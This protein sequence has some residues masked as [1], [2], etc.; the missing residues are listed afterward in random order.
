M[1]PKN[2]YTKG[3]YSVRTGKT[4]DDFCCLPSAPLSDD[5]SKTRRKKFESQRR[6]YGFD[7]R[8][9]WNLNYTSYVW[10]YS[11]LKALIEIDM[12]DWEWK[13]D[14]LDSDG[15][16]TEFGK[17]LVEVGVPN[18][19]STK[20]VIDYMIQRIEEADRLIN[21]YDK[22][23]ESLENEE[24]GYEILSEVFRIYGVLLPELWW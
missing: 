16:Y 3:L 1:I 15:E 4:E 18:P 17:C 10:I 22:N 8:E 20:A 6:R 12:V 9:L 5:I 19:I 2:K 23:D 13:A 7:E 24:K 21:C 14:F 11:H